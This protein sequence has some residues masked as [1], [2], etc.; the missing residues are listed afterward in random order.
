MSFFNIRI[1]IR[2][3]IYLKRVE[4]Q[5]KFFYFFLGRE[6]VG[7]LAHIILLEEKKNIQ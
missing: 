4:T 5:S 7:P 6:G 3:N 1:Y 2:N